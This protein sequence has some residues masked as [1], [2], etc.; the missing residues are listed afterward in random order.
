[1]KRDGLRAWEGKYRIDNIPLAED[2]NIDDVVLCEEG[3]DGWLEVVDVLDR[4]F[5]L[6]TAIK[7]EEKEQYGALRERVKAA[8]FKIEG[9]IG[10]S[11]DKPGFCVV[12]HDE[13]LDLKKIVE[14][15]G[16]KTP[17]WT[18]EGDEE[19]GDE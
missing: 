5:P 17:Q 18:G 13:S 3:S 1:M 4:K 9:M 15:I 6:K 2:L 11:G 16:I 14:E 7:Y 10:P 12:A 8:G 19:N